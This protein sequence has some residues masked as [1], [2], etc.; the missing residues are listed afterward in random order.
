MYPCDVVCEPAGP[1]FDNAT[2][3]DPKLAALDTQCIHTAAGGLGTV[4][5]RCDQDWLMGDCG[6]SQVAARCTHVNDIFIVLLFRLFKILTYSALCTD[7]LRMAITD[8]ARYS[9]IPHLKT[10][11]R[12]WKRLKRVIRQVIHAMQ[13]IGLEAFEWDIINRPTATQR[14][15]ISNKRISMPK[16][17]SLRHLLH[18]H[19]S[20]IH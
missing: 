17:L 18:S 16:P 13:P 7:H 6:V 14:P 1:D 9:T 8:C 3:A 20:W 2:T 19:R 4:Q 12:L 11:S 15:K 5:R 10:I